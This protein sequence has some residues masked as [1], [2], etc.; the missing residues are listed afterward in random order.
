MMMI[1]LECNTDEILIKSL[2]FSRKQIS[3]QKCKGE[4]IKRVGKMAIAVGVIDEDLPFG[5]PDELKKYKEKKSSGNIKLF[6]R[7]NDEQ[8]KLIQ[9]SPYLEDWL[10]NRAKRNKIEPGNFNLPDHPKKLHGLTKL[11]RNKNFREF[12]KKLID[13]DTEIQTLK[14]WIEEALG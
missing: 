3:H 2:G 8:K 7:G 9:I 12:L 10:L 13:A 14:K 11:E 5:Q 6:Q 1:F 4:V